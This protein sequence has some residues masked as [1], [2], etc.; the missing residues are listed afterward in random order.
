[1]Y[2]GYRVKINGNI[3]QNQMIARGS[4]SVQKERR[5]LASY[6]DAKGVKHEELSKR[7]TAIIKFTIRDRNLAEHA[8]MMKILEV[9]N[10]VEVEYWDD[11]KLV[12][13]IGYFKVES[14]KI[15][16]QNAFQNDIMYKS[17][18]LTLREY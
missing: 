5:V 7:E 9:E 1:M 17:M 4:Y 6:Y 13:N 10:N 3:V 18:P 15:E 14:Y 16:H 12:Y 11:K 2:Q 8:A